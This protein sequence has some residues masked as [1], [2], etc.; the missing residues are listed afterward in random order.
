M[1]KILL[2]RLVAVAIF[3]FSSLFI[4]SEITACKIKCKKTSNRIAIKAPS[5]KKETINKAVFQRDGFFIKI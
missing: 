1:K 4:K 3:C 2:Y 5:L